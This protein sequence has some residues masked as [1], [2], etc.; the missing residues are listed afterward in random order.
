MSQLQDSTTLTVQRCSTAL[1]HTN[2]VCMMQIKNFTF[3][4]QFQVD[5]RSN[6]H[7]RND[8]SNSSDDSL[9]ISQVFKSL[10]TTEIIITAT[11]HMSFPS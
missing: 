2:T 10:L 8:S 6:V 7:F 4:L 3:F 1:L 11:L 5:F 9:N